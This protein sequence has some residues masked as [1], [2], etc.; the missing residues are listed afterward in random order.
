MSLSALLHTRARFGEPP[1][2]FPKALRNNAPLLVVL[3]PCFYIAALTQVSPVF[4][5][6]TEGAPVFI[7]LISYGG[8]ALLVGGCILGCV[9]AFLGRTV[10]VF[11]VMLMLMYA[12]PMI[13]AL[14]IAA[15]PIGSLTL[16]GGTA[17]LV[18]WSLWTLPSVNGSVPQTTID[19]LRRERLVQ[20]DGQTILL[21]ATQF[22]NGGIA[23]TALDGLR[24]H[25][26]TLAEFAAVG[27]V[28]VVGIALVPISIAGDFGAQGLIASVIWFVLVAIFLAARGTVNTWLLLV[29]VMAAGPVPR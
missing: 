26:G 3:V 14:M 1:K 9:L 8:T 20:Q 23:S 11:V 5:P 18:V 21:P 22:E 7:R 13:A 19:A 4:G 17:A 16:L 27:A 12:G 2:D 10:S 29:R 15:V 25:F 28:A 24:S 6:F